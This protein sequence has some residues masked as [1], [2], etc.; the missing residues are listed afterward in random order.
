MGN[1]QEWRVKVL[2]FIQ[3]AASGEVV[4]AFHAT[5][6]EWVDLDSIAMSDPVVSFD[7]DDYDYRI[8]P[9]TI[10]IGDIEVPEPMLK[11]INKGDVYFTPSV[12]SD[13]LYNN[14][15]WYGDSYDEKCMSRGLVHGNKEAAITHAKALIALTEKKDA[16]HE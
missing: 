3:A 1:F 2:P 15:T 14:D 16:S 11:A 10:M 5:R 9:R 13:R 7:F 6:G 4:Q 8:K 12:T